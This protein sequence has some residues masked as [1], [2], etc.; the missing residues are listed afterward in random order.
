MLLLEL[1]GFFFRGEREIV[2]TISCSFFGYSSMEE[3][4]KTWG[5]LSLS[6]K[7]STGIIVPDTQQ[8]SLEFILNAKFMTSKALNMDAVARTFKQLWHS[9]NGFQ[10]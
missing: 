5:N 1:V 10:I 3:Q 6:E 7:E 2:C 8:H 9:T 4:T